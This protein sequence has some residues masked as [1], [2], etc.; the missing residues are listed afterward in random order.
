MRI[1][2]WHHGLPYTPLMT[3]GLRP[4]YVH[5]STFELDQCYGLD[6]NL[7]IVVYVLTTNI[8]SYLFPWFRVAEHRILYPPPYGLAAR[9][10]SFQ[11]LSFAVPC[12]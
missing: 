2:K 6:N 4:V 9:S 5:H 10:L 1:C 7:H 11:A 3:S 12:Q 8:S